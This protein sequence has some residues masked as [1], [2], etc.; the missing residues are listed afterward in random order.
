LKGKDI[1]VSNVYLFGR[2]T[3]QREAGGKKKKRERE[4]NQE[5]SR[6]NLYRQ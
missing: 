6:L 5:E 2:E 1:V 4:E 3:K